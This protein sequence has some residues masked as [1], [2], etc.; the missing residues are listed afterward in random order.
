M[1]NFPFSKLSLLL[2]AVTGL[3]LTSCGDDDDIL[4]IDTDDDGTLFMSSNTSGALSILDVDDENGTIMSFPTE[5]TDADG[6]YYDGELNNIFQ[7]DR[8]GDNSRI[9]EY[10]NVFEALDDA[11]DLDVERVSPST[12]DNGRGLAELNDQ[13]VVANDG[14]DMNYFATFRLMD[15]SIDSTATYMVNFNVWGIQFVG[16]SLYAVVDNSDSVAV[17]DNFLSNTP[18][19]TLEP[20]RYIQI[21]NVT[22]THGLQ[23]N[24]EDDIMLLTDIGDANSDSDGAIVVIESFSALGTATTVPANRYARI[25]GDATM[26]GNPVDVEYDA[27]NNMIYVAERANGGGRLLSFGADATGNATP[28]MM[29]MVDGISSLYFYRD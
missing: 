14:D 25:T 21:E 15:D 2:L 4:G 10:D 12:F 6:I 1:F 17:F 22:R 11:N 28:V 13:F 7:V 19:D 8:A 29:G 3:S 26:L 16:S 5:G 20:T 27:E 23:Y 9:V 18:G 24:A